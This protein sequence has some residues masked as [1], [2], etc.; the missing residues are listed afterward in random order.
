MQL[1]VTFEFEVTRLGETCHFKAKELGEF[2]K[3]LMSSD[4]ELYDK[5]IK[6]NILEVK[7]ITN[8]DG[9]EITLEEFLESPIPFGLKS[10][11]CEHYLKANTALYKAQNAEK[12]P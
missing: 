12:K 7:G 10:A 2:D 4:S 11:I 9:D 6:N 8:S 5:V 1:Y 3:T